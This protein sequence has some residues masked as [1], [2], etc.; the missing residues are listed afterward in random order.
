M[1]FFNG[2][3]AVQGGTA[4]FDDCKSLKMKKLGNR[5]F[6]FRGCKNPW[7]DFY[8]ILLKSFHG[9][10]ARRYPARSSHWRASADICR[11]NCAA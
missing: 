3:C 5:I 8:N 2:L 4:I 6:Q 1:A 9:L 11:E 10:M 7:K